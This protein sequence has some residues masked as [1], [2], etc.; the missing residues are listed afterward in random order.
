MG[1]Q[2]TGPA[3][4][5]PAMPN[6]PGEEP[7]RDAL[8]DIPWTDALAA[9]VGAA[10]AV[11]GTGLLLVCP[12][13]GQPPAL[14]LGPTQAFCGTDPGCGVIVWNPSEA[15]PGDPPDLIIDL[16]H[17]GATREG[18][19]GAPPGVPMDPN[20]APGEGVRGG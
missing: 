16:N 9:L 13:C 12:S 19:R 11:E 15:R 6:S 1:R 7:I 14:L 10:D 2:A 20:G 5:V 4:T 8:D 18:A 3:A 17:D